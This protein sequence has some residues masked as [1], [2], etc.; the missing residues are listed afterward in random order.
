MAANSD[1]IKEWQSI[2]NSDGDVPQGVKD[3]LMLAMIGELYIRFQKLEKYIPWLETVKWVTIAVGMSVIALLWGVFT[4][5][6]LIV[7]K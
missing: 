1:L 3:R 5:T 4:H 7:A 6:I 2:L